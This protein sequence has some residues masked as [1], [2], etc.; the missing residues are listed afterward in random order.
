[1][2]GMDWLDWYRVGDLSWPADWAELFGRDGELLLEIG[3]GGG[4]FLIDLAQRRPQANLLGVEISLPSLRKVVRKVERFGLTNIRLVQSRAESM[5]WLLGAPDSICGVVINFP[6]PWPKRIHYGRRLIHDDFLLLLATRM[7]TGAFLEVAT[8]DAAYAA[9]IAKT[10]ARS[11]HFQSRLATAYT[12]E[13]PSRIVT[14][15]E[16]LA[17]DEG[18]TCHYFKW[19][20]NDNEAV[21][22]FL[23]PEELPMPHMILRTTADIA[24]IGRRFTPS[25]IEQGDIRVK[26]IECYRSL[27]DGKLMIEA[28]VDEGP[29]QQQVCLSLRPRVEVGELKIGLHEVGFPR[30]TAGIH[31]AIDHLGR[32]LR[33]IAPETEVVHSNLVVERRK[34]GSR[35]A[36]RLSQFGDL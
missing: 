18:R 28:L 22:H 5:L 4:D 12:T 27:Y 7:K 14:K 36:T 8:D 3:F 11:P 15:Y 33:D 25:T 32:W 29:L 13:D 1:M 31:V 6:D 16:Q 17:K 30:P 23:P 10:L 20:R 19:E 24:E 21:D 9:A 35:N 34:N 2:D 26:F